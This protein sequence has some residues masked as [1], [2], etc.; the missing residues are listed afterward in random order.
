MASKSSESEEFEEQA[1]IGPFKVK[2]KYLSKWPQ[3]NK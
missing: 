1:K 3:E 2:E